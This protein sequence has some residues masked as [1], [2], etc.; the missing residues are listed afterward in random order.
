MLVGRILRE[1]YSARKPLLEE[2]VALCLKVCEALRHW[3]SAISDFLDTQWSNIS[4][5][6]PPFSRQCTVLNLAYAHAVILACRPLLLVR[7]KRISGRQTAEEQLICETD[8]QASLTHM[9]EAVRSIFYI[10]SYLCTTDQMHSAFWV[11]EIIGSRSSRVVELTP[12]KFTQ[13]YAFSALSVAYVS[14]T[15]RDLDQS[16]D[17]QSILAEAKKSQSKLVANVPQAPF[18]RYKVVLEELLSQA[19]KSLE[20]SVI[21]RLPSPDIDTNHGQQDSLAGKG[22][23]TNSNSMADSTENAQLSH[24]NFATYSYASPLS[25]QDAMTLSHDNDERSWMGFDGIFGWEDLD[26]LVSLGD[27]RVISA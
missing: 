21:E 13:Y 2:R 9:L 6:K 22:I 23:A 19:T 12:M 18:I 24:A 17:W 4:L 25:G 3:R 10:V 14:I 5:M 1:Q 7:S 16:R 26:S 27:L 11:S 20:A 15:L 8:L